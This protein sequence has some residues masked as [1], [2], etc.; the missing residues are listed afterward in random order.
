MDL[1]FCAGFS[2]T[3]RL[4]YGPTCRV[5]RFR[6]LGEVCLSKGE[7]NGVLGAE[8]EEEEK[9]CGHVAIIGRS[10]VGKSTLMNRLVGEKVAIVTP[11]VQ[12]TRNRIVGI[13][14]E[15]PTQIIFLVRSRRHGA[16]FTVGKKQSLVKYHHALDKAKLC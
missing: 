3:V 14:I 13:A 4:A 7:E 12:T 5:R 9:R 15:P 10:N 11:K 6:L 2:V 8:E 16:I 1:G